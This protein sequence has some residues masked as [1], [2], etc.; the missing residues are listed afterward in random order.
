MFRTFLL[1]FLLISVCFALSIP[2]LDDVKNVK[3]EKV[4]EDVKGFFER[5]WGG[6]KDFKF[7]F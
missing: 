1:L 7:H 3:P 4:L 6:L 2:S 5:M